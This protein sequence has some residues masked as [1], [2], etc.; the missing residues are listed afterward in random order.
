MV[1]GAYVSLSVIYCLVFDKLCDTLLMFDHHLVLHCSAFSIRWTY[2]V[3]IFRSS[4]LWVK[5]VL[6]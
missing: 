1:V 6:L 3:V 4:K 5:H 2:F